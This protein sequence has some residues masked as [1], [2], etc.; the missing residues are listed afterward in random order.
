MTDDLTTRY[1]GVLERTAD[2]GVIRF[3]RHLAYDVQEVWDAITTPERLADWWLPF[4]ADITVDLREGGEM[5][6][7]GTSGRRAGHHDL[8]HPAARAAV[9]ARAH[10]PRARVEHALGARGRRH[11]VHPPADPRRPRRPGGGRQLLPRRPA[12]LPRP[13]RAEP[14]RPA[15]AV[16]LGRL[17]RRPGPLRRPRPRRPGGSRRERQPRAAPAGA[18]LHALR[19]TASAPAR[20]RAS[21]G[22]S[23]T[24]TPAELASWAGATASWPNRTDPGGTRGLDDYF[25]RDF[26]NNIGAEIMGR[27][28]FGPQKGPWEDL[29][30]EGWWGD[31]AAVPHAGVRA[32]APR[33]PH[34]LAVGHDLPLHRRRAGR[35]AAAG[36]GRRRRQGRAPRRRRVDR[37]RLPRGRPRRHPARRRRP[38]RARPRRKL[39]DSPDELLDRFHLERVP[40]P[41]GVTHHLFWRR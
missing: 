5:V 33:A 20:A 30:W 29:E 8:H 31:D 28:K 14:R 2:G 38:R 23:A 26:A 4:E 35:G 40:S 34:H 13:A 32:D 12:D 39:W 25:T 16:G 17:R 21:S 37:P 10:P 6:F 9:A 11:R 15:R 3:E 19:P 24:P 18:E 7:A 22:P 41:S 1:D 36:E 27:G